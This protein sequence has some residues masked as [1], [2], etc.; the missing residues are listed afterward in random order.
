MA[1]GR[2]AQGPSAVPAPASCCRA[3]PLWRAL[4]VIGLCQGPLEGLCAGRDWFTA[5]ACRGGLERHQHHSVD[6]VGDLKLHLQALETVLETPHT[7]EEG[8]PVGG[9]RE[10]LEL[11]LHGTVRT[12]PAVERWFIHAST[13]QRIA[14][15]G[16]RPNGQVLG[17][18]QGVSTD[19]TEKVSGML[20][21]RRRWVSTTEPTRA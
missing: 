5:P 12:T 8:H 9:R 16:Y 17:H 18:D 7:A 3:D 21:R 1:L 13:Q 6:V 14:L 2:F 19:T 11:D 10:T 20:R 4:A 15:D